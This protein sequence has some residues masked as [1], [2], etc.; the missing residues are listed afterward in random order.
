MNPKAREAWQEVVT[1]FRNQRHRMDYPAYLA[2][3]WQIGSG[4][5]ESACKLVINARMNGAGMR[6]SHEGADAI[7]HLR[8]LYLSER[9]LWTAFWANRRKAG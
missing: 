5:V 8:A 3:G 7:G 4:P 1:Y 6:W 2:K 9:P